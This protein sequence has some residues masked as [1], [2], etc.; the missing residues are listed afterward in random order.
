MNEENNIALAIVIAFLVLFLFGGFSMMGFGGFGGMMGR[1]YEGF[2]F[3][4]PFGGL[5]MLLIVIALVLFIFWLI[6]QMRE[7]K[8]RRKKR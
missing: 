3:M 7:E 5:I 4:W 8:S 1:Y 6:N 2:G